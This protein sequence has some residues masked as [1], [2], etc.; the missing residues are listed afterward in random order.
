M[1]TDVA[2]YS[3]IISCMVIFWVLHVI[4]MSC[5]WNHIYVTV[6]PVSSINLNI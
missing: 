3:P 4:D 5:R 6:S 1:Y 2:F